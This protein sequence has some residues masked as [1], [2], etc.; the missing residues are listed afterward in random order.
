[1]SEGAVLRQ[2]IFLELNG[3]AQQQIHYF[4]GSSLAHKGCI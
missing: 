3:P 2:R 4:I 1:M